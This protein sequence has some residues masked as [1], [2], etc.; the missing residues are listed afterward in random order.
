MSTNNK[1]I[2]HYVKKYCSKSVKEVVR[3]EMKSQWSEQSL[4]G[5]T[6]LRKLKQ[7]NGK[8]EATLY[9]TARTSQTN[10]MLLLVPA[11]PKITKSQ[12]VTHLMQAS[13]TL[14]ERVLILDP[15]C[16]LFRTFVAESH[17]FHLKV[18][19]FIFKKWEM[20]G[21][22]WQDIYVPLFSYQT[23]KTIDAKKLEFPRRSF[24]RGLITC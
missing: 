6:A 9:F 8:F 7:D 13:P 21:L 24:P 23:T 3:I 10:K 22:V 2:N 11:L 4:T 12:E 18:W 1:I 14:S 17:I 16:I 20:Y 5:T 15:T 19:V